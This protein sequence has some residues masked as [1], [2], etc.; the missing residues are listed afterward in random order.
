MD[1]CPYCGTPLVSKKDPN[2][3]CWLH[4]ETGAVICAEQDCFSGDYNL[5]HPNETE[6]EFWEHEE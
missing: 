3:G 5:M 6:E 2:G 1:Y 4:E